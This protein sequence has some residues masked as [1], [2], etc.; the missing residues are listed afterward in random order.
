MRT[1]REWR[2]HR[3]GVLSAMAFAPLA[4]TLGCVR[5]DTGV[6]AQPAASSALALE[7]ADGR[8][9]AVTQWYPAG[10]AVGTVLFSHGAGSS[11]DKYPTLI[12]A[13]VA[14]GWRVLAPLHV[15]S[16][17][18]PHTADYPG[19]ASWRTR[20]ED[21]HRLS[22]HIG[23]APYVAAGHSYG[24][25]VA[26]TLGGAASV[27]PDGYAGP[28]ADKRARAVVAFSPPAPVPVLVTEAGYAALSVPALIQTG[29]ADLAPGNTAPDGW[30]GHLVPFSAA[31]A[32]HNR[33]GL[34]L[35]G[36]DHYFGGA[37]CDYGKPGPPQLAQ[38]AVAADLSTAFLKAQGLGNAAAQA[39]L[40]ARLSDDLPV[41]LLRR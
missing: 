7:A 8:A 9:I 10:R 23:D 25:L 12:D 29:T 11:P 2:V 15:D 31:A 38:L 1:D 26:L 22:A 19:L 37:I 13:W 36:V 39:A 4:A 21:M 27:R 5:A 40:D 3:R 30:R 24:G 14:A 35:A 32:G 16:R 17:D 20:L 28:M 34:V 18:H 6:A 33:Y 41:M